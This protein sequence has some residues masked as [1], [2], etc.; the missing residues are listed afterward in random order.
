MYNMQAH[1]WC[2][3]QV[4]Q[5]WQH[6]GGAPLH[7]SAGAV[8]VS[9]CPVL[10]SGCCLPM[11]GTLAVMP[12]V[13]ES[14]STSNYCCTYACL[15]PTRTMTATS[16]S[17][18]GLSFGLMMLGDRKQRHL[19]HTSQHCSIQQL[20]LYIERVLMFCSDQSVQAA[21]AYVSLCLLPLSTVLVHGLFFL[22]LVLPKTGSNHLSVIHEADLSE[23]ALLVRP[24][25]PLATS[26]QQ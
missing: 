23:H 1:G 7:C 16:H 8:L 3:V 12:T 2:Q 25:S 13:K 9:S 20:Q 15:S 17:Q 26:G 4:A 24:C 14:S 6:A 5:T 19:Q 11:S 10:F 18:N 21:V 22:C